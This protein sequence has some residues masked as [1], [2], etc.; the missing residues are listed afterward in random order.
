MSNMN[1][2]G[3]C[4]LYCGACAIYRAERDNQEWRARIA[5]NY[6]C[7]TDQVT[8]NGC[9]ALTSECLG[10]GCKIVLCTS[11]KGINFCFE[12]EEY[13]NETCDKFK[14]LA[15]DYLNTGVNL[16]ENLM[17]IKEGKVEEWLQESEKK[18]TCK[19][20][21][22]PLAVWTTKCHHCGAEIKWI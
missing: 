9:N 6:N 1:L 5:K 7:T 11:A 2:V 22:K 13:I 21:E 4:G 12:C 18:Y 19:V 20:C 16:R 3:R 17:K 8:C 10:N 15:D 14:D